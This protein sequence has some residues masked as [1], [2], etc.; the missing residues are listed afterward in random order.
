MPN[1]IL[2]Y[3]RIDEWN[4]R[5]FFKSITSATQVDE[6]AELT[7]R[8]NTGGGE[9]EYGWGAAA[10]INEVANKKVKVDGKA[11]SWGTFAC[12]YC[13]DVECL[14]VSQFMI[15]RASYSEWFES[16]E[17]FTDEL[18]ENLAAI[19]K[20]LETAFRNKIDVEAFENLKQ[21]KEKGITIKSIFSMEGKIDVFF[22]ASDAKKI[23]LVKTVNQITPSKKTEIENYQ[24]TIV[25]ARK[26]AGIYDKIE[27]P[28]ETK[29][30]EPK[31]TNMT[32]QEL[33]EKFPA[34]YA[35]IVAEG[36]SAGVIAGIAQEK[37]RIEAIMVFNEIDPVAVTAAIESGKPLTQKALN[38][39]MLK[40]AGKT[41]VA[42]VKKDSKGAIEVESSTE[43][44]TAKEKKLAEFNSEVDAALGKK[45]ET[46]AA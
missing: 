29:I 37:E 14:D 44:K 17:Y 35:F 45:K 1:D 32:A 20:K 19:N 22:S 39:L 16:S 7:F 28:V 4:L 46:V 5:E 11:Y 38:E 2:L 30:D 40:S 25:Q 23:G 41:L 18:Q 8:I 21:V 42:N 24:S 12:C 13:D 6:A 15:H 33:K 3:G 10:K 9:P 31:I 27:E 36:H 34:V 43:E 26:G